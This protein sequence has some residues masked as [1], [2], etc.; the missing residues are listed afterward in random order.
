MLCTPD[1][2]AVVVKSKNVRTSMAYYGVGG[3]LQEKIYKTQDHRLKT[4]DSRHKTQDIK[5][6]VSD[7][8]GRKTIGDL[9]EVLKI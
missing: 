1:I 3:E 2:T 5:C 8:L 6:I 4:Q 9:Q 7:E